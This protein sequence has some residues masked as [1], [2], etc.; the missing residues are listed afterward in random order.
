MLGDHA[1]VI[2]S[3]EELNKF[4]V[5]DP[6]YMFVGK[7]MFLRGYFSCFIFVSNEAPICF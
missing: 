1:K 2:K 6:E 7:I 4:T 3:E 5:S